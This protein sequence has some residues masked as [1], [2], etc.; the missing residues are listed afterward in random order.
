VGA[1]HLRV[2][3]VQD[4]NDWILGCFAA[5][6]ASI[7]VFAVLYYALYR[8][9]PNRFHFTAGLQDS[10]LEAYKNAA[11]RSVRALAIENEAWE[12]IRL[13]I[14]KGATPQTLAEQSTRG[15][16]SSGTYRIYLARSG[17]PPSAAQPTLELT[18]EDGAILSRVYPPMR[19]PWQRW[20]DV[21]PKRLSKNQMKIAL[22]NV[23]LTQLPGSAHD[24]WS[25]W[26]FL[27]FSAVSQTT[28][29]FG[30]ILPNATGIRLLV[31]SQIVTGY[32]LLVVLLNFVVHRS[33]P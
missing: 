9:R 27:Y 28:V 33:G 16:V 29:G 8:R 13:R 19:W 10:Q 31:V 1:G 6:L 11:V 21:F 23:R 30:D 24:I 22:L 14:E 17:P 15:S 32:A 3:A 20:D 25:F 2:L 5:Y 18:D 26:D 7:V 12:Q 4:R